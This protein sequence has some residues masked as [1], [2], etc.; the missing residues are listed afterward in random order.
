MLALLAVLRSRLRRRG[1]QRR[2]QPG[3][4]LLA[5]QHQQVVLLVRQHVLAELGAERCELLRDR[6]HALA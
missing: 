5:L 4:V 6:R 1:P 2:R 3:Q